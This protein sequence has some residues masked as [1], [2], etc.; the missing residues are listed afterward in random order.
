MSGLKLLGKCVWTQ[1]VSRTK[2]SVIENTMIYTSFH[3]RGLDHSLL[4]THQELNALRN[5][6]TGSMAEPDSSAECSSRRYPMR[7]CCEAC[8]LMIRYTR[9]AVDHRAA[10][11]EEHIA[12]GCRD[13]GLHD[14]CCSQ[15]GHVGRLQGI[16]PRTIG[17]EGHRVGTWPK[18]ER[19]RRERDGNL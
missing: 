11:E 16:I 3:A 13:L 17:V 6:H 1:F 9:R 15:S 2:P 12:C 10:Q 4:A 7:V 14:P 8:T 19:G 5:G 18:N